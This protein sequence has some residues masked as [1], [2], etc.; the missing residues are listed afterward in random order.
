MGKK[1][2][3]LGRSLMR[4]HGGK[5]KNTN[6]RQ[7][8]KHTTDLPDGYD[9]ARLN[10][11]SVTEQNDLDEF[12]AT[13]ELAGT[14]FIGEK[15]NIQFVNPKTRIG[16]LSEEEKKKIK[17]T[18]ENHKQLLSIPRRPLWDYNTTP[19]QL[20]QNEKNSFLEWRRQLS[21]LEETE[22]LIL[23]P[24]EK[25]LE[26]WRQL[27][28]VLEK[29]DIIVQIVDARNPLLYRSED[30]ERYVKELGEN[31]QNLILVNKS[32]FLTAEQ[33]E[34]WATYFTQVRVKAIF[35]SALQQSVDEVSD[36]SNGFERSQETE[37]LSYNRTQVHLGYRE[38]TDH[39]FDSLHI[40]KGQEQLESMSANSGSKI[41]LSTE[42]VTKVRV[43]ILLNTP[44]PKHLTTSSLFSR[45][46]LITFFKTY[47]SGKK[48][49]EGATT[50]GLVG[51]PNVGK[52]S[53]LNALL[54][55]KKVS[56]STTPGKTKHFQTLLIDQ[57]LILC[58]CPGLVFPTFVS[59]KAEMII[60]GILPI[61]QMRD[62]IPQVELL[63]KTIPRDV[64]ESTYNIM[65]PSPEEGEDE[66]R[67]P[68]A[69]EL[70][71]YYGYMRG[72]M[73]SR[74]LPD[75]AR[76][77]R[78]I[79]KDF[80]SG[81]LLYCHPPPGV[82]NSDYQKFLPPQPRNTSREI[83]PHQLRVIK[84]G[85]TTSKEIDREFFRKVSLQVHSKGVLSKAQPSSET[86]KPW[87][88]HN[89]RNKKLKLRKV[90]ADCDQ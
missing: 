10:L 68:T 29:S 60:N 9:W 53:T 2:E 12:L 78:F 85:N 4:N 8:S 46:H 76:T 51:Y 70:L 86:Q 3:N 17:E 27:W 35:F 42:F 25:N 90:Y 5:G 49:K 71:N 66:S 72:F 26:F 31:K 64:L 75:T 30:L 32:D 1:Q 77:A 14:E 34:A 82:E 19:E 41:N 88:K 73:G 39:A 80:V 84:S 45:E 7:S 65:L 6:G 83:M 24:Y 22:H 21:Q 69:E 67:P 44:E 20:D 56:V 47:H 79:L 16:L 59:T 48:V 87:K 55:T 23:T 33:R 62:H 81:K 40:N 28:R 18:Q 11:R 38:A 57:E 61:D 74:G 52:S 54:K 36:I 58:D 63:C 89:N 43:R 37:T 15:L 13:A 50:V